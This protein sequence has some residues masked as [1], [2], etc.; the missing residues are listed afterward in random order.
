VPE[1]SSDV[2]GVPGSQEWKQPG[3]RLGYLAP[4]GRWDV[5]VDLGAFHR[6]TTY[7]PDDTVVELLP[8]IQANARWKGCSPFVNAGIGFLYER[9]S[10]F[11]GTSATRPVFGAGIGIRKAVSEGHG[12]L[13]AEVRYDHVPEHAE[14][15]RPGATDVFLAT[16]MVSVKLGFDLVLGPSVKP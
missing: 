2:L 16:N 5:N 7:F 14:V 11:D 8:Q 12:L 13:R 15:V 9:P 1:I 10:A 4:S 6:S 3:L